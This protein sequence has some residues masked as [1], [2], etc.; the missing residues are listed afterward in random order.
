MHVKKNLVAAI[1]AAVQLYMQ[2]QQQPAAALEEAQ[3]VTAPG[4]AFNAWAMSGR[5][6]AMEL[7]R[8]WQIR[9]SSRR[10]CP[11]PVRQARRR[12]WGLTY[13]SLTR[14]AMT[15]KIPANPATAAAPGDDVG[16]GGP[17]PPGACPLV[18]ERERR[19]DEP[20]PGGEHQPHPRG[21]D[22]SHHHA[23]LLFGEIEQ[24]L[25]ARQQAGRGPRPRPAS[26]TGRGPARLAGLPT[27]NRQQF[28]PRLPLRQRR[29]RRLRLGGGQQRA[30]QGAQLA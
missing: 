15:A 3:V 26:I 19:G 14:P 18:A 4:P 30:E 22:P 29:G 27:R 13:S 16:P 7:R 20:E 6:A 1:A 11:C 9:S 28:L 21:P 8:F 10:P 12:N 5:Q 17:G 24:L 25:V 2:A 23:S